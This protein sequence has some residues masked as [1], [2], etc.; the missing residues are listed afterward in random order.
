MNW[1]VFLCGVFMAACVIGGTMAVS[2]NNGQPNNG[3]PHNG[4]PIVLQ[5]AIDLAQTNNSGLDFLATRILQTQLSV[6][7]RRLLPS[8]RI[9][10]GSSDR[11]VYNNPDSHSRRLAFSI[12]QPIGDEHLAAYERHRAE[13]GLVRL[14]DD[15]RR[16]TLSSQVIVLYVG[17]IQ[18][19]MQSAIMIETLSAGQRQLEVTEL[20]LQNGSITRNDFLDR[21]LAVKNIELDHAQ[22]LHNEWLHANG[23]GC[24]LAAGVW[25]RWRQWARSISTTMACSTMV[26]SRG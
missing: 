17:A 24:W 23:W 6:D 20:E 9:D 18:A 10:Y 26:P 11:V 8:L 7:V 21:V 5:E 3:R 16:R 25:S 19:R 4:R 13:L 15:Q 22:A 12:R 1:R 14:Q 2:A